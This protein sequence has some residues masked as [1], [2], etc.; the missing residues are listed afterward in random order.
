[1]WVFYKKE[2]GIKCKAKVLYGGAP[3]NNGMLKLGLGRGGRVTFGE[4]YSFG[5]VNVYSKFPFGEI[6][7]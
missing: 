3:R 1:M 2:F 4:Q 7:V 5:F 6:S